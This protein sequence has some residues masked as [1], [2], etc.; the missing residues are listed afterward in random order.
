MLKV[1]SLPMNR[2]DD[3]QLSA[4][5]GS[6]GGYLPLSVRSAFCIRWLAIRQHNKAMAPRDRVNLTMADHDSLVANARAGLQ[7]FDLESIKAFGLK[8]NLLTVEKANGGP[9]LQD[10]PT[11]LSQAKVGALVIWSTGPG[12]CYPIHYPMAAYHSGG[13]LRGLGPDTLSLY[14]MEYGEFDPIKIRSIRSLPRNAIYASPAALVKC[15]AFRM[16]LGEQVAS[17]ETDAHHVNAS[18][19]GPHVRFAERTEVATY[20]IDAEKVEVFRIPELDSET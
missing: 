2:P 6:N 19:A 13:S 11:V 18:T 14:T 5:A 1:H 8:Y 7:K 12:G 4:I 10:L 16:Q 3:A 15:S 9:L 17:A 20:V